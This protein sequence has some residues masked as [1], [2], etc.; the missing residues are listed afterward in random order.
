MTK[1][2]F[3]GQRVSV[4]VMFKYRGALVDP[5]VV[6]FKYKKPTALAAV[7]LQYGVNGEVV[8][9]SIGRYH[10][11]VNL[12][13]AGFMPYRFEALGSYQGAFQNKLKVVRSNVE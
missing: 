3:Y 6:V 4:E 5:S 2:Y 10:V 7:V 12:D 11:E 13:D 9:D 8:R 1:K